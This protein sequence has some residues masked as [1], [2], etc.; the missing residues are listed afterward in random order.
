ML[1]HTRSIYFRTLDSIHYEIQKDFLRV[2]VLYTDN[3]YSD[4]KQI[5]FSV[6]LTKQEMKLFHDC[7]YYSLVISPITRNFKII[8]KFHLTKNDKITNYQEKEQLWMFEYNVLQIICPS[9]TMDFTDLTY[10]ISVSDDTPVTSN[11]PIIKCN[12]QMNARDYLPSLEIIGP[13]TLSKDAV[14]EYTVISD[15]EQDMYIYPRTTAGY[16]ANKKILLKNGEGKFSFK[17]LL[18][19]PGMLVTLTADFKQRTDKAHIDVLIT[20]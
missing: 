6:T 10:F 8:D 17:P 7:G 3:Y 15:F 1:Y 16:L 20:D 4:N 13:E 12:K 5:D 14:G 2:D 11:Q 18:L 19:D 9:N